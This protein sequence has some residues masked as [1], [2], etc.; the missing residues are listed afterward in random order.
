MRRIKRKFKKPRKPWDKERIEVEKKLMKTYGLRRK[1]EIWKAESILRS[2]R[3]RAR[4]LAA[5]KDKTQEKILLEKL[6]RLGLLGKNASLDDVLSLTVEDILERRLQTI[7]FKSNLANT[8]K[9]ARQLIT[10][11]HIAV[12]GR[13]TVYPSFLVPKELEKKISLLGSM[14]T[15]KS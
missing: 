9:H 2:F 1:R 10:H 15:T 7:V 4:D 8:P 13:R 3:R 6:Q 14:K 12:D 5:K 11:G